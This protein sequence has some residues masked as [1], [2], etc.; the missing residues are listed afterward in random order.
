MP[1]NNEPVWIESELA[2][3]I[4][5]R[6]LAEHGGPVGLRDASG[7]ESALARPRNRWAYGE[8]ELCTLAAAYAYGLA[9]N[10]PFTDGNKR[11]AWVLARLFLALNNVRIEFVPEDAVH[12]VMKLAAGKLDE[13]ELADWF[14][15][16]CS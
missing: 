16:H 9:R 7:L 13:A 15:A 1:E 3:A 4:H 14:K 12:A 11:T 8:T 5:D 2:L 6:Q 10:H